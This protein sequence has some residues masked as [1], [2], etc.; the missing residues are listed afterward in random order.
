MGSGCCKEAAGGVDEENQAPRFSDFN[1]PPEQPSPHPPAPKVEV[2]E[3]D[4]LPAFPRE[5]TWARFKTVSLGA[6]ELEQTQASHSTAVTQPPTSCSTLNTPHDAAHGGAASPVRVEADRPLSSN[7]RSQ[8]V[9]YPTNTLSPRKSVGEASLPL[10][11]PTQLPTLNPL[12]RGSSMRSS[13]GKRGESPTTF[14]P[15]RGSMSGSVQGG[16]A[17]VSYLDFEMTSKAAT[18][19]FEMTSKG[20]G[21]TVGSP[22]VERSPRALCTKWPSKASDTNSLEG[23]FNLAMIGGQVQGG[24]QSP[25]EAKGDRGDKSC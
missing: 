12:R 7:E 11:V 25:V 4:A 24:A 8:I 6:L 9:T 3:T 13:E 16:V 19:G 5:L 2:P 23:D 21:D 1:A 10:P 15:L 14:D 22:G 17:H 20:T 18:A